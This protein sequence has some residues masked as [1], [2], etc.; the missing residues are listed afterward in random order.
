MAADVYL[1][2]A[3]A[4]GKTGVDWDNAY[5]IAEIQTAFDDALGGGAGS[6]LYIEADTYP[7]NSGH[8]AAIDAD[9]GAGST[10][11]LNKI[12]V[13]NAITHL[14]DGSQ[15]I[16]D[17]ESTLAN[18]IRWD[19]AVDYTEMRGIEFINATD[20]AL[21]HTNSGD[22]I[23]NYFYNCGFNNS[24]NGFDGNSAKF[25]YQ[26]LINCEWSGNSGN[27]LKSL[28]KNALIDNCTIYNNNRGLL[29]VREATINNSLI[30]GNTLENCYDNSFSIFVNTTIDGTKAGTNTIDGFGSGGPVYAT[31]CRI[32]N[33]SGR[34]INNLS[35]CT[36]TC[37]YF[38]ANALGDFSAT[39][40]VLGGEYDRLSGV[41]TS[42]GYTDASTGDYTLQS[43]GDGVGIAVPIGSA[44]EATNISYRTQGMPPE[45]SSGGGGRIPRMRTHGV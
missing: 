41:N 35:P 15:A 42:D 16:F 1:T 27:G 13:V 31:G 45:Y 14:E 26:A 7:I 17:G 29:T 3:G 36:S 2:L 39:I 24:V 4:L 44:D 12:I 9:A 32:T 37:N 34:G 40:A 23:R 8:G 11:A 33:H 25:Q 30:Y 43:D 21:T 6:N 18:V 28:T 10:T 19:G 38:Y 20:D 5:S 22:S